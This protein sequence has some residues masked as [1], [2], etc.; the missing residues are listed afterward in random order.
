M[1]VE[2][3]Q[4]ATPTSRTVPVWMRYAAG[5]LVSTVISQI[6]LVTA[7]GLLNATAAV[8]SI[9]AFVVGTVPNY[10]L[11]KAWVW[12]HQ[13]VSHRR[14]VGSYIVVMVA[15]NAVAIAMTLALDAC[16]RA[17]VRAATPR[18]LLLSLAYVTSYGLMFVIKYL[19]FDGLLFKKRPT[20]RHAVVSHAYD[21]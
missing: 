18:T 12:S 17:H 7:Y 10:L 13:K 20:A 2:R 15:T 19:L 4:T 16:V 9:V 14:L 3:S 1:T 6:A 5:S 21:G 11:N 8:A